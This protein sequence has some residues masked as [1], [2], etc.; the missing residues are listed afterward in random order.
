MVDIKHADFHLGVSSGLSW[1]SWGLDTHTVMI[2]DV[3]PNFHEFQTNI[4]RL[5]K[6]NL[7]C[8][9][10]NINNHTSIEEVLIKLCDLIE[11]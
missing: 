6:N 10:Y 2:S 7:K 8:V 5:N 4:T 11:L 3:T 9:D 1:L